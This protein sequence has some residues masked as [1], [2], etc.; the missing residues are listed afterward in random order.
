MSAMDPGDWG[1]EVGDAAMNELFYVPIM[2]A[3]DKWTTDYEEHNMRISVRMFGTADADV[4]EMSIGVEDM[5]P[6]TVA[7]DEISSANWNSTYTSALLCSDYPDE[8]TEIDDLH[9]SKACIPYVPV[10]IG[11][12]MIDGYPSP[13]AACVDVIELATRH[14]VT[15]YDGDDMELANYK[16]GVFYNADTAAASWILK[17]LG[18]NSYNRIVYDA[19]FRINVAIPDQR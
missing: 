16:D 19:T 6:T 12:Y 3:C 18:A 9:P 7:I 10:R 15:P 17:R 4:A 1:W 8:A 2:P 11:V 5:I 14:D 13:A